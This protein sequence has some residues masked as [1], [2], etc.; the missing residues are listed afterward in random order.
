MVEQESVNPS[1]LSEPPVGWNSISPS[2]RQEPAYTSIRWEEF[3]PHAQKPPSREDILN[4]ADPPPRTRRKPVAPQT[5]LD[6]QG[7]FSRYI[8]NPTDPAVSNTT[9]QKCPPQSIANNVM[10]QCIVCK[11]RLYLHVRNLT[12]IHPG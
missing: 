1:K 10:I 4:F 8:L 3:D 9:P 12:R 2:T 5:P 6:P 11:P 7:E